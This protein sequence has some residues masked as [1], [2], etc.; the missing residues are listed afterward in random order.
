MA[1]KLGRGILTPQK[2]TLGKMRIWPPRQGNNCSTTI[3]LCIGGHRISSEIEQALEGLIGEIYLTRAPPYVALAA[4]EIRG[5]LIAD[6]GDFR[7]PSAE[8]PSARIIIRLIGETS[9]PQRARSSM[10]SKQRSAH[11]PHP[12]A[13]ESEGLLY[14]VQ[15]D[16]TRTDVIL[17]DSVHRE[18]LARPWLTLLIDIWTLTILGF[19]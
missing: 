11:E 5:L 6:N 2:C 17:V 18:E 9:E 12:G 8:V 1:F 15:I 4:R 7:F 10:G 3:A 16:H 13:Y 19:M 14:L